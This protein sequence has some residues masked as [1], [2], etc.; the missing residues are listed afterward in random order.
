MPRW[1][2]VGKQRIVDEGPLAPFPN[3]TGLQNWQEGLKAKYDM[4]TFDDVLVESS[5]T[6]MDKAKKDGKTV[7][8]LAQHHAHARVQLH[9]AE[10]P[11]MMNPTSNYNIEEAGMAQ[12]DDSIGDLLKHLEDIGEPTTLSSS[13]P[14]TMARKSSPGP[15]AA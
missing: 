9:P 14:P 6:F 12:M 5:K 15:T 2:K 3:M 11:A 8:R 7:L 10:V 1:G 4:E 13:S